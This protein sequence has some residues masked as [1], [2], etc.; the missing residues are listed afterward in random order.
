MSGSL[1][2]TDDRVKVIQQYHQLKDLL[3]EIANTADVDIAKMDDEHRH[4]AANVILRNFLG[5][6]SYNKYVENFKLLSNQLN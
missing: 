3:F 1:E 5:E 6:Q 4:L 2:I